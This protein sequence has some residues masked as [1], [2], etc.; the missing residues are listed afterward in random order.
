MHTLRAALIV[1][2]VYSIVPLTAR[3]Q[4]PLMVTRYVDLGLG[5]RRGG[6]IEGAVQSFRL[7]ITAD[8][9]YARA[10][11]ELGYALFELGRR[12]E[13]VEAFQGGLRQDPRNIFGF[14]QIGYWYS[15]LGRL[16]E[17]VAAFD[18]ARALGS[19][20]FRDRLEIGYVKRRLGDR[21]GALQSF[22]AARAAPDAAIASSARESIEAMSAQLAPNAATSA[23][24]IPTTVVPQSGGWIRPLFAD[25]YA[26]PLYQTRFS[27]A[28]AQLVIRVGTVAAERTR[29][30]PYLSLRV[31]RDSRSR[32]G[33]QPVVFS[34]NIAV[35][36]IGMRLQP[37]RGTS[38]ESLYL[39]AEA[40]TAIELVDAGQARRA[41]S[42]LRAGSF[43]IGQWRMGSAAPTDRTPLLLMTDIYV[44]ASYYS[45]FENTIG[46]ANFRESLRLYD[47]GGRGLDL[48]ARLYTIGDAQRV[49]Y[50]N[51]AEMAGGIALYP[52]SKRQ[53]VVMLERL[54]GR[55]LRNP[56]PGVA[57]T[58][59]DVRLTVVLSAYRWVAARS[60]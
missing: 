38:L 5:Q 46:S 32:G 56:D 52:E 49:Y 58:Y 23:A 12:T 19:D 45:R 37:L 42:D 17:S 18:S 3:A 21:E 2:M 57:R 4:D 6:D 20:E 33:L 53:V 40:G 47:N 51:A 13:A 26:A 55:Y 15:G 39:Y 27:N 36:A 35:P 44:D 7:A 34:D 59:N 22:T 24:P 29:L 43:Y 25:F 50:N 48:F 30:S 31:T 28:I 14:R 10:W 11:F 54:Q 1:A 9:T 60:R 16:R 8:S 41:R